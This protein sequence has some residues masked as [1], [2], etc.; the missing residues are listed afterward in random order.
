[1][2][3]AKCT[4]SRSRPSVTYAARRPAATQANANVVDT[5]R[6]RNRSTK[7]SSVSSRAARNTRSFGKGGSR[8]TSTSPDAADGR[9]C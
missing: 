2:P 9:R 1:M 7:P 5:T 4:L 8:L 3:A 6:G